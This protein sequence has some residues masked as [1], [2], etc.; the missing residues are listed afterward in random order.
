MRFSPRFRVTAFLASLAVG[1]LSSCSTSTSSAGASGSTAVKGL[2]GGGASWTYMMNTSSAGFSVLQFPSGANGSVAPLTTLTAPAGFSPAGFAVDSAGTI[3]F[4]GTVNATGQPEILV[5]A[6]GSTGVATP[7]RTILVPH[8]PEV[9]VVGNGNIYTATKY[10]GISVFPASTTGQAVGVSTYITGGLTG[11]SPGASV[12]YGDPVWLDVDS[13]GSI[14]V[15]FYNSNLLT[16]GVAVFAPGASGNVSPVREFTITGYEP[17]GIAVDSSGNI[18]LAQNTRSGNVAL[19]PGVIQ[20]FGTQSSA[21]INS[22][23]VS[24]TTKSLI[25]GLA[26]D[27]AGNLYGGLDTELT[28]APTYSYSLFGLA[29]LTTG[30]VTPTTSMTSAAISDP[31]FFL[32]IL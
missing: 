4:G 8:S 26:V 17:G 2:A 32:S 24:G 9:V 22:I 15:A 6:A 18:F 28:T 29:P 19:Q 14:Y 30:N 31:F 16:D 21:A 27:R 25:G 23:T 20:E 13:A 10:F 7:L 11:I 1:L 12:F 3:Y 5:Y